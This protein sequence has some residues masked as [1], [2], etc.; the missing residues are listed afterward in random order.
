MELVRQLH[1]VQL[2]PYPLTQLQVIEIARHV[3]SL[4]N[5]PELGEGFVQRMIPAVE[6]EP[7]ENVDRSERL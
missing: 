6:F 3:L 1:H 7:F 4:D 5:P 2:F